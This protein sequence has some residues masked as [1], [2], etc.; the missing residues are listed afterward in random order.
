MFAAL[1]TTQQITVFLGIYTLLAGVG[2]LAGQFK[3]D[4]VL[5]ELRDQA[6]LRYFISVFVFTIG[7]FIVSVHNLWSSP[8]EILASLFGWAALIEG[9]LFAAFSRSLMAGFAKVPIGGALE[10]GAAIL[11]VLLGVGIIYVSL[12]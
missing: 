7:A 3:F 5:A 11:Y 10:R 9:A 8:L 2:L 6:A 12:A 4:Q 1:S